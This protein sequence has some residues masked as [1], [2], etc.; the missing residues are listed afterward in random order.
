[1]WA[2]D[3]EL[4][5]PEKHNLKIRGVLEVKDFRQFIGP[6]ESG[7]FVKKVQGVVP[8]GAE[9]GFVL[10]WA[11]KCQDLKTS[12]FTMSG[13]VIPLPPRNLGA[14]GKQFI[15]EHTFPPG[16][17]KGAL[18]LSICAY[19]KTS[20]LTVRDDERMFMNQEGYVFN[21]PVYSYKYL[22]Q[23]DTVPFPIK[24]V[25][26]PDK[27]LWWLEIRDTIE[28]PSIEMF[29][30]TNVSICVNR[31]SPGYDALLIKKNRATLLTVH[32]EIVAT[33]YYLLVKYLR[34]HPESKSYWPNMMTGEGLERNT[35]PEVIGRFLRESEIKTEGVSDVL[36]YQRIAEEMKKRL[37]E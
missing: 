10:R 27:P 17:I 2:D 6:A 35:I 8:R 23:P 33:A 9:V 11:S 19:V 15:F 20:A 3:N 12:A 22:F 14:R 30:E 37:A 28:D 5:S 7:G 29:Q 4:W 24:E 36:L 31:A 34:N 26:E 21:P 1:M 13:C 18:T 16:T 25:M 32:T